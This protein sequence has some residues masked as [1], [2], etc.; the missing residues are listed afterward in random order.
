MQRQVDSVESD[1]SMEKI[2]SDVLVALGG[3][4]QGAFIAGFVHVRPIVLSG[5][6]KQ[7]AKLSD[8]GTHRTRSVALPGVFILGLANMSS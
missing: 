3:R 6:D 4:M 8:R 5:E 1:V 2:V 7:A